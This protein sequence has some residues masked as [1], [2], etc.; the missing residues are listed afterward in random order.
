MF[1]K[2]RFLLFSNMTKI[3]PVKLISE[4]W[5]QKLLHN[6]NFDEKFNI[7]IHSPFCDTTKC[8]FCTYVSTPISSD[9]ELEM[10][11]NYYNKI[12]IQNI[13][14]FG[15]V[16]KLKQPNTIYFGGG[17]S[18]LMSISQM[19][20]IFSKLDEYMDFK[21]VFEKTFELNPR[22]TTL[23][24]LQLLIENGFNQ[25]TFG[26]QS[27]NPEVLKFNNRPNVEL[28]ILGK[29][30]DFLESHDVKYNVDL[31]T[32]IYKDNLQ[33]DLQIL[34]KDLEN[35]LT[36]RPRRVTVYPNLFKLKEKP[37]ESNETSLKILKLRNLVNFIAKKH[38]YGIFGFKLNKLDDEKYQ[39][40]IYLYRKDIQ[41]NFTYN[42]VSPALDQYPDK[43]NVLSFGGYLKCKPYSYIQDKIIYYTINNEIET[44]YEQRDGTYNIQY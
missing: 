22:S 35:I 37:S 11:D 28:S 17:T 32:F 1:K 23:D 27:T 41:W 3:V 30:I 26:Y 31:M 8:K 14:D 24:K 38:D 7:Y 5:K 34:K 21:N 20:Q 43:Q 13:S 9:P 25:F 36:L 4:L 44:K 10:K 40:N 39:Y 42:S 2:K 18:S 16:L 19:K 29:F 6:F 33:E 12:L 15:D